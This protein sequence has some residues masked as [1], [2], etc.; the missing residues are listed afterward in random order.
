MNLEGEKMNLKKASLLLIIGLLYTVFYK[1]I[2]WILP[3]VSNSNFLKNILSL[4][5]LISA[6]TIIIFIYFFIK[7]VTPLN[8]QIKISLQLIILFTGII[9]LLKL[10]VE[11]IPINRILRNSIF[12]AARLLNSFSILMFFIFF[13]KIIPARNSLRLPIRLAIWGFS[14][15]LIL[16]LIT[17]GYY[18]NFIL[19]GH[20]AVPFPPLQFLA[21]IVFIFTYP[22][23][24]NFLIKFSKVENYSTL[25]ER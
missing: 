15:G 14:I 20:E 3:A 24:I 6:F 11:L 4:L 2:L 9:V 18:I 25:I 17:F 8:S 7:E 16:G 5:W 21:I 23:I 13:N 19:T 12:E 10:P 1:V 22:V